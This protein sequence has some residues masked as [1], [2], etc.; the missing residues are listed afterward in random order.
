MSGKKH[1]IMNLMKDAFRFWLEKQPPSWAF[2]PDSRI[3]ASLN[4]CTV[5]AD[6][7]RG[8][9]CYSSEHFVILWQSFGGGEDE[10]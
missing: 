2:H 10:N 6:K 3:A 5:S 7:G 1:S 4:G 9:S 8:G